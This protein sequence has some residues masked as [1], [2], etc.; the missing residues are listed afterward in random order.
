MASTPMQSVEVAGVPVG[1]FVQGQGPELLLVHGAGGHPESSFANLLD[2]LSKSRTVIVPGYSGSTFTPL[3]DGELSFELLADQMAGVLR[4]AAH[5]P[6]D[7]IGFS[8]GAGIAAVLATKEPELVRRM[9][10]CGGFMH[11]KDP[12]QRTF[13]K[14]WL[15]LAELDANAFAD[16]TVIHALSDRYLD[17]ISADERFHLRIGL[18]P[19]KALVA[20]CR[21]VSTADLSDYM[22]N[23]KC[24]TLV[25]APTED[26]LIPNRYTRQLRDAIPG[27]EY[28]EV[29]S[30]HLVAV[31]KPEELLGIIDTFLDRRP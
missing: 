16:Y 4:A 29:E 7:V 19:S 15:K 26:Q 14:I 23:I 20:M 18:L 17:S 30:G 9:M 12:R 31:E 27:S 24:P 5:G 13:V 11:Y 6:A 1:Y 10:F 8:T 22:P 28:I 2:H 21:L 25:V 3:P